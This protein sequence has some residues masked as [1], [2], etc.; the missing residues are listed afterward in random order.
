MASRRVLKAILLLAA[1]L[2]AGAMESSTPN[3]LSPLPPRTEWY[4]THYRRGVADACTKELL[5]PHVLQV[6]KPFCVAQGNLF[7]YCLGLPKGFNRILEWYGINRLA[8][9]TSEEFRTRLKG[10]EVEWLNGTSFGSYLG[11]FPHSVQG[12][13]PLLNLPAMHLAPKR[14]VQLPAA[15]GFPKGHGLEHNYSIALVRAMA[16]CLRMDHED[17]VGWRE[18]W[19]ERHT[20][21][22][23]FETMV[24]PL[25]RYNPCGHVFLEDEWSQVAMQNF[26]LHAYGLANVRVTEAPHTITFLHRAGNRYITNKDAVLQMLKD[27][28]WDVKLV[29]TE[30]GQPFEEQI[31]EMSRTGVLV[32]THGA[33]MVNAM[34][35]PKGSVVIEV[36]LHDF[37]IPCYWGQFLAK[38]GVNYLKWCYPTGACRYASD[39]PTAY[40]R[41]NAPVKVDTLRPVVAR[42]VRLV[43]DRLVCSYTK[44]FDCLPRR[45]GR[46]NRTSLPSAKQL[47]RAPL[48]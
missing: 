26:R 2:G 22:V 32:T 6:L 30:I 3:C 38:V 37:W 27:F 7:T 19:R 23:C 8:V 15:D 4:A 10:K 45:P 14:F 33:N 9:L 48:A 16:G 46:G 34:F 17:I 28:D 20:K 36:H 21:T 42:A 43:K 25:I 41:D 35:M 39:W 13:V 31:A 1:H 40:P 44:Q 12:I 24:V 5:E 18:W 11:Q 29:Q 47:A